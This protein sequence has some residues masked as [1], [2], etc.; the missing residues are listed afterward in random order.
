MGQVGVWGQVGDGAWGMGG[1]CGGKGQV[2]DA[3]Q[4]VEGRCGIWG[5]WEME[6][7]QECGLCKPRA[8]LDI[9][10]SRKRESGV[11]RIARVGG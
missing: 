5:R 11:G 2:G 1:G 7:W 3:A 8:G 6:G 10:G 4:G 9:W